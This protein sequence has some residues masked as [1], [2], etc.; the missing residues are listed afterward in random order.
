MAISERRYFRDR[1]R[2]EIESAI[3]ADS[4]EAEIAHAN[5]ASLH[6]RYCAACS[7]GKTGE[8]VDCALR[9]VCGDPCEPDSA[10]VH[11][12]LEGRHG[13]TT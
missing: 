2:Q 4:I 3:R 1:A 11:D 7:P 8:C 6:L 10:Q 5:L 13:P 9:H 12:G